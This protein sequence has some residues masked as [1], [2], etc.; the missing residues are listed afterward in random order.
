[1]PLEIETTCN[2]GMCNQNVHI[3]HQESL[4]DIRCVA[5]IGGQ[6]P[7]ESVLYLETIKV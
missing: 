6:M 3:M 1:M 2:I 5:K 4:K 7:A